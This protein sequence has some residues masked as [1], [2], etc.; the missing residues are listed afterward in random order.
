LWIS[1]THIRRLRY[2]LPT[3]NKVLSHAGHLSIYVL[4]KHFK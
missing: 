3:V 1:D 2:A 4:R